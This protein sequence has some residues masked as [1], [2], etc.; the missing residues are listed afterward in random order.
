VTS[1]SPIY[2]Y[3]LHMYKYTFVYNWLNIRKRILRIMYIFG[4]RGIKPTIRLA[5]DGVQWRAL[6]DTVLKLW[7]PQNVGEFFNS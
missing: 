2:A 3:W 6:V 5:T 4:T 1:T 7:V